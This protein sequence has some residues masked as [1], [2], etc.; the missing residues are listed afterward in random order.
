MLIPFSE[1]V[2]NLSIRTSI[3]HL[4]IEGLKLEELDGIV[5]VYLPDL[6]YSSDKWGREYSRAPEYPAHARRAIKEMYRQVGNLAVDGDGIAVRGVIVRHLILPDGIAGSRE[7]LEWLAGELSHD[8][9]VSIMSQYHPAYRAGQYP[10]LSRA[11]SRAE[12]EEVV[13]IV[14]G[15]GLENGWLQELGSEKEYLPDF[16][17]DN[18]FNRSAGKK[19]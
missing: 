15:L 11:I 10:P 9:T 16:Q 2:C 4:L 1:D 19:V 5:D 3:R 7:T 8:I 6:R 14:N 18:P 12:Y 17:D 13:D